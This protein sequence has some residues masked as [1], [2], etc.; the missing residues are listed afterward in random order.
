MLT[1]GSLPRTDFSIF[2]IALR[3]NGID[4][5]FAHGGIRWFIA[6]DDKVYFLA[7]SQI[8]RE[9]SVSPTQFNRFEDWCIHQENR[10]VLNI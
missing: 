3:E 10:S 4:Y 5:T 9:W 2:L 1:E 8:H 7:K 6:S